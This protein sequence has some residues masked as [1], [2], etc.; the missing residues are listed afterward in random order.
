MVP[1]CVSAHSLKDCKILELSSS[2][3]VKLIQ[4]QR[5]LSS[6]RH[7]PPIEPGN[8]ILSQASRNSLHDNRLELS[9]SNSNLHARS[10]WPCFRSNI[11]RSEVH[12]ASSGGATS[13][14]VGVHPSSHS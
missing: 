1:N 7:A 13:H 6:H 8:F 3:S 9:V 2:T 10:K 12:A 14:S 5:S 11:A 4:P